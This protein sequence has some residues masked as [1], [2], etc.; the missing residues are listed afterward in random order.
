[1]N[2][3]WERERRGLREIEGTYNVEYD[4]EALFKEYKVHAK[5]LRKVIADAAT[6]KVGETR[7]ADPTEEPSSPAAKAAAPKAPASDAPKTP[8]KAVLTGIKAAAAAKKAAGTPLILLFHQP[9]G[10]FNTLLLFISRCPDSTPSKNDEKEKTDKVAAAKEIATFLQSKAVG[11]TAAQAKKSADAAG[12]TCSYQL[13]VHQSCRKTP[14]A[15][16]PAAA[17]PAVS[18]RTLPDWGRSASCYR[19]R[20]Y[21]YCCC[22]CHYCYYCCWTARTRRA[23]ASRPPSLPAPRAASTVADPF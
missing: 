17:S 15:P 20:C 3:N 19:Y 13:C 7:D 12:K 14:P 9:K 21:R 4:D 1:M 2:S 18:T 6:T 5:R 10:K 11:M 8:T 16:H 23:C 22:S